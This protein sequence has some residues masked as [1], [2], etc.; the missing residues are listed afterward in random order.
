VPT[1]RPTAAVT[2]RAKPAPVKPVA[3][4]LDNDQLVLPAS[5][6][7]SRPDTKGPIRSSNAPLF[8]GNLADNARTVGPCRSGD[9]ALIEFMV[10]KAKLITREQADLVVSKAT[11]EELPLDAAAVALQVITEDALVNALTQE[12]WVPHL[13]VDKYEIRKKALD[14]VSREDALHFSVFPV[15]KLGQL[16]TLAMV[17]PLDADTI[18]ILESKTNLD[19]KKVVATRTEIQQGIEKY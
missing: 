5:E 16:L 14:T 19:I 2:A 15:D 17:N 8:S 12:C 10:T 4:D 11:R 7:Q 9:A 18:R 1:V 13:K 3:S 6:N